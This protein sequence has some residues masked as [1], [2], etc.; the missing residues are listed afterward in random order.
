MATTPDQHLACRRRRRHRQGN[1]P[2]DRGLPHQPFAR[3]PSRRF[4]TALQRQM[5]TQILRG[6][7]RDRPPLH[8]ARVCA[9]DLRSRLYFV[10]EHSNFD[11]D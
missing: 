10:D 7:T 11:S 8:A 4:A 1:H 9:A 2:V 5:G 6:R 3:G